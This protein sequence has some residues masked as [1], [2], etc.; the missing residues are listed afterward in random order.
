M[1]EIVLPEGVVPGSPE[2]VAIIE[3]QLPPIFDGPLSAPAPEPLDVVSAIARDD[4]GPY[5]LIIDGLEMM[6]DGFKELRDA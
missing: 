1:R 2:A 5:A 3:S 6:L 4:S